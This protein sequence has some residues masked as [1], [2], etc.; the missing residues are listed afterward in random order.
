LPLLGPSCFKKA[1]SHAFVAVKA[2][3][4]MGSFDFITNPCFK[5][6]NHC[7]FEIL[8]YVHP[9]SFNLDSSYWV[10]GSLA[11]L[12]NLLAGDT[13]IGFTLRGEHSSALAPTVVAI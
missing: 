13:S 4:A 12:L 10:G 11:F 9:F 2:S 5:A 8:G 3:N 1:V 7:N 6:I